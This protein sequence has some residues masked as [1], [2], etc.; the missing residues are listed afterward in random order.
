MTLRKKILF[1]SLIPVFL[2]GAIVIVIVST[3]VRSTLLEQVKN[4]LRGTAVAT[5]AAYEQNSGLYLQ[6][7]NGDVWKGN[8]NISLSQNL[9]DTIKERSGME[10]TFF[11]G[12]DRVMTSAV[13]ARGDRILGSPAGDKIVE[14]VLNYGHDYFSSNVVIDDTEYFGYYVPVY[15][16]G[17]NTVPIGIVFAG[18][19]KME[20]LADA[21]GIIAIMILV[22][23]VVVIVCMVTVALFSAYLSKNLKRSITNVQA[24]SEGKLSVTFDEAANSQKDEIGD[25][26]RSIEKLQNALRGIIGGIGESTELLVDSSDRLNQIAGETFENVSN[27]Q[28]A[29]E[30]MTENAATQARDTGDASENINR[31]G[32]LIIETGK[33][34]KELGSHADSMRTSSDMATE[35]IR[36]LKDISTEVYEVVNAIADLTKQTNQSAGSIKEASDFIS[37]IADQTNLLA[38]NA[39]IEAARAGDAGRGFS[40]VAQE[41]QK[42]AEQS[43][44]ASGNIDT[45]VGTLIENFERV[46]DAMNR[47]QEVIARQNDHIGNTENTVG[48][49]MNEINGS[50]QGIRS[51]QERTAELERARKEIVGTITTLS[52]IAQDNLASMEETNAAITVVY[53]KFRH[54]EDA[55]GSLR[56]TSDKLA[57]NIGNFEL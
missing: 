38:L 21:L 41:I 9:V 45:T 23:V 6:T 12:A 56:S 46:V 2:L 8:Y 24:V 52:D 53:D 5:L 28:R 7:E 51:I 33:D 19:N 18:A 25:L 3:S 26:N 50:I 10:V 57:Q 13:D 34:A 30:D 4:S 40:V 17:D 47:M 31:M 55:A 42:L 27:V 16:S 35:S 39:S 49:V 48:Q 54:V 15:Q 14:E 11:Y 20:T 32:E 44:N 29:I 37:E 43:N 22:V 1:C 36:E